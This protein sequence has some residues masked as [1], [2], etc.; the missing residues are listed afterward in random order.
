MK[1]ACISGR[2]LCNNSRGKG[3]GM[4]KEGKTV[5]AQEEA[6]SVKESEIPK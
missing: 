6:I 3:R 5:E 1:Q 2:K 4:R